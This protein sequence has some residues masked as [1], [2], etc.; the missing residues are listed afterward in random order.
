[1]SEL[2][3]SG[4]ELLA[5]NDAT[6]KRWR[7]FVTAHPE[8]LSVPCDIRDTA[9]VG[10]LLQHIVAVELR[11]AQ[12]LAGITETEYSAVPFGTADEILA[13]HQQAVTLLRGVMAD[14]EFDWTRE[15][16]FQTITAGRLKSTRKAVFVHALMH[17]IRHYAQLATLARQHGFKPDWAMDYLMMVARPA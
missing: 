10:N 1:M 14:P 7:D 3:L 12:R 11:Y 2:S 5:W 15:I 9:T 16:E 17:S 4:E 13:S 8:L 6:A